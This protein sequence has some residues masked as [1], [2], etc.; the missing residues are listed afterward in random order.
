[1]CV[2]VC[3]CVCVSSSV[4]S[5]PQQRRGLGTLGL[6]SHEKKSRYIVSN[7]WMTVHVKFERTCQVSR[8]E[9]FQVPHGNSSQRTGGNYNGP[10]VSRFRLEPRTSRTA[11]K[12][13]KASLYLFSIS[14]LEGRPVCPIK[15]QATKTRKLVAVQIDGF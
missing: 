11:F 15:Q 3:V 4:F 14:E 8:L 9:Q 2:C 6:S 5:K 10:A 1:V 7:I 13:R 12:I